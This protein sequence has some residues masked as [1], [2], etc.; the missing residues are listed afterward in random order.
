[1]TV[2]VLFLDWQLWGIYSSI[3][4]AERE[5]AKHDS[6]PDPIRKPDTIICIMPVS[7]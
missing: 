4:A 7:D 3:E 6:M 1:M 5:K 2:Y